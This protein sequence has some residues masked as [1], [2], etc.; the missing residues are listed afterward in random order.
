MTD[1]VRTKTFRNGGSLAVRIPAGWVDEGELSLTRDSRTGRIVIT[2]D[3][4]FN[5]DEFFDYV[6]ARD[7]VIDAALL[8]LAQRSDPN[9]T[10]ILD[11]GQ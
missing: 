10:N 2:Q 9:R 6:K 7:F 3:P 8:E 1:V 4:A 5:P 11:E